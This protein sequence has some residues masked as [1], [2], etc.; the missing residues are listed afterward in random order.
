MR[1]DIA[2]SA[3]SEPMSAYELKR[4]VIVCGCRKR[5]TLQ[6][7]QHALPLA[8]I[9]EGELADYKRMRQHRP[10]VEQFFVYVLPCSNSKPV[11]W[12]VLQ[13]GKE[14]RTEEECGFLYS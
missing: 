7:R 14:E 11:F 4:L 2:D 10:G 12:Q 3:A 5:E 13:S 6:Q 1:V 9:V 8:Q